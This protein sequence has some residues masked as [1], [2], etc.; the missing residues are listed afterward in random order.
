MAVSG[1]GAAM[2]KLVYIPFLSSVERLLEG[3]HN[4]QKCKGEL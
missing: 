3:S 2:G 1:D 4:A